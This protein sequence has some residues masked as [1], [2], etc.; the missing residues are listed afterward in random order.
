M[1]LFRKPKRES[2]EADMDPGLDKMM[3]LEKMTRLKAR[4]PPPEDVV[5]ALRAFSLHKRNT[6][7]AIADN[8]ARLLLQSLQYGDSASARSSGEPAIRISLLQDLVEALLSTIRQQRIMREHVDLAKELHTRLQG[9]K[10]RYDA[11]ATRCY[12]TCLS[13]TGEAALAEELVLSLEQRKN[14][15]EDSVGRRMQRTWMWAAV[16]EGFTARDDKVGVSRVLGAIKQRG[17]D[18]HR[19]IPAAMLQYAMRRQRPEEV[20]HWWRKYCT[21]GG[22]E[23]L[24][25][26]IT[27]LQV[28][29]VLEWCLAHEHLSLGHSIVKDLTQKSPPKRIWDAIFVWAAGTGKGVEEIG[30]MID[31]MLQSGEDREPDADTI[32][33]LVEYATNNNDPYMAE[34]FI[35]LGRDRG[36]DSNAKTYALQMSYRLRVGDLDG[37]LTAYKTLQTMDLSSNE[38]IP[39]VNKLI[40][41]LCNSKRH[42]FDTVM[43]IAA[44]LSD[45]RARFEPLTVAN[46]SLVHLN[47]DEVHDVVDLLN[48]HAFHYSSIERAIVR[49]ALLQYTLS[50]ETPIARSWDAYTIL[51]NIF[52]ELDRNARTDVMTSF[53]TRERP[54]MAVNVFNHMR[55]HSREDTMPVVDTY[56]SAFLGAA[57]LKDLESLEVLHNQLK[58]DVNI[59]QTT[60]LRNALMIAYTACERPR[61]AL[62]FWDNIIASRE[63]PTYESIHIAFRACER[64]N[65]GDVKARE[66]WAKL[67]KMKIDLDSTLWASYVAALAGN[68]DAGSGAKALEEGEKNGEVVVDKFILGSLFDAAPGFVKQG[69]VEEWA[70]AIYPGVWAE[71]DSLGWEVLEDETRRVR[72]DRSVTP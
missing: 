12:A 19:A 32:N 11:L 1:G 65:F 18:D 26:S 34:R 36:I 29:D 20:A 46:L 67:R 35:S 10:L 15:S 9:A 51:R 14:L 44:D 37:A 27:E 22:L 72:I 60:R 3:E 47:R 52:D 45:R 61:K 4:L 49:D 5:R 31:V 28:G 25:F 17:L 64:A 38:D 40:V 66:I 68:G 41:A 39:T 62:S 55:F 57:R 8:Q 33:A 23:E 21:S 69:E 71:V 24:D 53:F 30:R 70:K 7:T 2:R 6:G 42:D 13:R 59:N 50:I 43:N 58:L 48:T 16:L 63:G 56:I 54:D